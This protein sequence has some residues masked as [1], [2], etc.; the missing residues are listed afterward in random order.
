[1][2]MMMDNTIKD[3]QAHRVVETLFTIARPDWSLVQE[4]DRLGFNAGVSLLDSNGKRIA[5]FEQL[6]YESLITI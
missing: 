1:M 3:I 6:A 2:R 4:T 5:L